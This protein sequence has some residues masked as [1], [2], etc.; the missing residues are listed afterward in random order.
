MR[1]R[2]ALGLALPALLL[3]GQP[4]PATHPGRARLPFVDTHVHL[5]PGDPA[6]SVAAA[7]AAMPAEHAERLVFMP[8]PFTFEDPHRYD[9]E[10][11]LPALKAHAG[12]LTPLGGGGSLNAMIQASARSGDAGPEVRRRFR[13]R[14]EEL[15]RLGAAGFGELAAEH[16]QGA[17]PAQSVPPDH[18]L[19]LLLA[20][21]A[22]EHGVPIVLHLEA[23][24][25]AQPPPGGGP[26]SPPLQ[27]NLEA[28]GRL[29]S[30]QP[31]ARIIWAHAGW[32]NTGDRTPELCRRLLR[33]HPNLS[34]DLKV[35]PVKPGRN[36]LLAGGA[37]KPAWR[38]L[39]RDFPDRFLVGSDQHYPLPKDGPQRWEAVA[40][41]LEQLPEELRDQVA[42][43][44]ASKVYAFPR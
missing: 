11:F 25:Q 41:L 32:D 21:L 7:L 42:L 19:F 20:D 10:A 9:L 17:T 40:A 22:A 5:E 31:R 3:L 2:L 16:F 34:M 35:D 4:T 26:S 13:E 12:K 23:V 15:L 36:T 24:L 6:A 33:E 44:N 28:L 1:L 39:L 18:P 37:L 14:A 38:D 43:G 30:H 8:P 27:P 29:L